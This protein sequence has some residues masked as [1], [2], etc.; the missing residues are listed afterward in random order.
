[1]GSFFSTPSTEV[2][3]YHQLS[4]LDIDKQNVDFSTLDGKVRRPNLGCTAWLAGW[5][6]TILHPLIASSLPL[7]HSASL[8]LQSEEEDALPFNG[9]R[10]GR[11]GGGRRRW[12]RRWQYPP[13]AGTNPLCGPVCCLNII[14]LAGGARRERGVEMRPDC[15]E[16]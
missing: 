1:M 9:V 2:T 11:Q 10:H 8:L 16:L 5:A 12:V 7:P 13:P 14:L 4:A 6:P 15:R 3:N